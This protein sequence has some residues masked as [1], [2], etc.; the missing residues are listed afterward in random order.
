MIDVNLYNESV[1]QLG[2]LLDTKKVV[3]RKNNGALTAYYILEVRYPSGISYEHYFYPDDKIL[4]LIGKDIVFDR[5]DYNQE[6]II[7]HIY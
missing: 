1:T 6:K 3:D 7:T 2:V 4:T 5:I